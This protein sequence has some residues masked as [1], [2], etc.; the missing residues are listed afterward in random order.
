[1]RP[2]NYE[3]NVNWTPIPPTAPEN[4][5]SYELQ[6]NVNNRDD[7]L[8]TDIATSSWSEVIEAK[9][10]DSIEV[11]IRSVEYQDGRSVNSEWTE[12]VFGYCP[13]CT[14]IPHTPGGLKIK[15]NC[16]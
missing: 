8:V 11:R 3:V 14:R 16:Q 4:T 12:S 6:Y 7:T 5:I 9:P 2:T 15:V 10:G 1:M 13:L